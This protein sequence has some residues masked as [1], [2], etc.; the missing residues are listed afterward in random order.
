MVQFKFVVI[1][2]TMAYL[3]SQN[4]PDRTKISSCSGCV[5]AEE[6]AV[7]AGGTVSGAPQMV[8]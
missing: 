5:F 6:I 4:R 2:V 8:S 7:M 1:K 3:T